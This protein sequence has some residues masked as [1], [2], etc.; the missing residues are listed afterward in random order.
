MSTLC[1]YS[2][3]QAEERTKAKTGKR[4]KSDCQ[5]NITIAMFTDFFPDL[6]YVMLFLA[7]IAALS[8]HVR[9]H[10]GG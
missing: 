5:K 1:I 9:L 8:V 6:Y 3:K 10:S 2:V 4:S 7:S